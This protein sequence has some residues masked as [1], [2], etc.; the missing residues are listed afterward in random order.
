VTFQ[1]KPFGREASAQRRMW[2]VVWAMALAGQASQAGAQTALVTGQAGVLGE[3]ELTATVTEQ[4]TGT[5]NQWAGPLNLTHIGYLLQRRWT[6][7][8]NRRVAT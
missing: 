6:G 3:W 2:I 1:R 4:A 7:R 5:G 8:E